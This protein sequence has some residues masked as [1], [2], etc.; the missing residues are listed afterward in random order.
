MSDASNGRVVRLIN[1][2]AAHPTESFTLSQV[3]DHLSLSLGSAHRLLKTLTEARYLSRDPHGKT[4][5]LG[6]ALV[7]VGQAALERH[8]VVDLARAE[9]TT[10]TDELG[11]QCVATALVGDELISLAKTGD[12]PADQGIRHVGERR[13]FVPPLGLGHAAWASAAQIEAYL[14]K[15]AGPSAR[16]DAEIRAHIGKALAVIRARGY[17]LAANGAA[18]SSVWALIWEYATHF[19][20]ERYW[21]QMHRLLGALSDDELQLLAPASGGV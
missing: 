15:I 21:T 13:P 7:A 10:L 20:S 12:T 17:A 6:L 14:G 9:M 16:R 11:L 19:R 8:P 4:Y 1:F 18:M 2:F 5:S 3:V